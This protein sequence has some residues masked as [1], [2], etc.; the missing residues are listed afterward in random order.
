LTQEQTTVVGQSQDGVALHIDPRALE[1]AL[2]PTLE[3]ELHTLRQEL[4]TQGRGIRTTQQAFAIFAVLAL[5]VGLAT[6]V[7]V[8]IKLQAKP[9]IRVVARPAASAAAK[10]AAAGAAAKPAA[11]PAA[12]PHALTAK[13][14]EMAIR[15]DSQ[16][17][18]AGAVTFT[19]TNA[20]SVEHEFVVLRTAQP[21]AKLPL[22]GGRASEAGHVGELGGLKPGQT[23]TLTLRLKP[24]H[25]SLICNL[26]GHYAGGMHADLTVR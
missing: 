11:A 23:K 5:A 3:Q 18:A 8:A 1:E 14:S 2:H 6:F 13:L 7:T 16:T 21:A 24:G 12:A 15:T 20:G 4:R 26:P 9:T 19:V 25:Y 17:A 22:S 10:P